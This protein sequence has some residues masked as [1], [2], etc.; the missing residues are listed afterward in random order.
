MNTVNDIP[1]DRSVEVGE[2]G[3]LEVAEDD[4][5][6]SSSKIPAEKDE[7]PSFS[8]WYLHGNICIFL[9][10][11]A[12]ALVIVITQYGSTVYIGIAMVYPH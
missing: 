11:T 1:D 4:K 8:K 7:E 10:K 5:E 2:E 9:L 6:F 12:Y 3:A